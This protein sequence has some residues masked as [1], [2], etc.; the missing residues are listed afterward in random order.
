MEISK[1]NYNVIRIN[2]NNIVLF[3]T[4]CVLLCNNVKQINSAPTEVRFPGWIMVCPAIILIT[5]LP[6]TPRAC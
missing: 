5:K 6:F 3:F 4:K 2:L 1:T